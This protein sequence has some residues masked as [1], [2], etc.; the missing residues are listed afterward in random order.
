MRISRDNYKLQVCSANKGLR[1]KQQDLDQLKRELVDSETTIKR[2]RSSLK[3]RKIERD[4]Y[5][6]IAS[7]LRDQMMEG[8]EPRRSLIESCKSK[9]GVE[10]TRNAQILYHQMTKGEHDKMVAHHHENLGLQIPN[11]IAR[12]MMINKHDKTYKNPL[13]TIKVNDQHLTLNDI[14][15]KRQIQTGHRVP[16]LVGKL[17]VFAKMDIPPYTALGR[18]IGFEC[19]NKEWNEVFDFTNKDAKHSEYLFSFDLDE[20]IGDNHDG[21]RQITIDPL[22]GNMDDLLLLYINDIRSNLFDSELSDEDK[23]HQN[24]KFVVPKLYGWPTPIVITTK[25]IKKGKEL[26]LDYGLAF[27]VLLKQNE[28]WRKLMRSANEQIANNILG[29]AVLDD[30]YRL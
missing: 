9:D 20:N 22:E 2:L 4:K 5:K 7:S 19:T 10:R 6:L 17:G 27:S 23:A 29:D 16:E 13:V 3:R 25:H 24:C 12:F 15:E 8:M 21:S 18:Y 1:R 14:A 30:Y 11:S 26:L 28:R